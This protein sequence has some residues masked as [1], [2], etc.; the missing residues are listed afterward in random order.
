M[1]TFKKSVFQ[2]AKVSPE[3]D[4]YIHLSVIRCLHNIKYDEG[5]FS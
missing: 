2:Q 4:N 1:Q 5:P 3:Y